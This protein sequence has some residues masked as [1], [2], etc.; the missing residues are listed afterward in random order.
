MNRL[1]NYITA[2]LSTLFIS[3]FL[4][5]F[6]IASVILFIKLATYTAV[7]QLSVWEMTKLYI[8]RLPEILFYTLPITF[9]V[10]SAL[11]LLK[12]SN[13]NEIVVIFALGIKPSYIIKTLLKPALLLSMVLL[14]DFFILFPHATVLSANFISYKK[15]EAKF[16]LAASEFGNSF[17]DW[18]LYLGKKE[19]DGSFSKV[20]L[21]NKKEKEEILIASESAKLLNDS[22]IL[23][24]K[25]FNGQGYS[26]SKE[27]FTQINF[28]TMLINDTMTT[29]IRTYKKPLDFWLSD[30][31]AKDKK[32]MLIT[33]LLMSL[34]PIITL[35]F[36]VSIGVVHARHGKSQIYLYLFL[37]IVIYYGAT[38]GLQNALGYY[39]IPVVI[40]IWLMVTYTMYRK[41]IVNRF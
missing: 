33:D 1:K 6:A 32:Q 30:D 14:L 16:N 22:G 7:I 28:E 12:L 41:T 24:L 19:K 37:G 8:F 21:F 29:N 13:D 9:F 20:F 31:R 34:F 25:L 36:V 3:I 40:F 35:F 17:G 15:S 39:T 4:P 26:Y 38:I 27:K 18:L 2:N 23:R 11:S 5:L 10:A